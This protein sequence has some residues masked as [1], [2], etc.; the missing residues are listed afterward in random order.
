MAMDTLFGMH[1]PLS[2]ITYI[3]LLRACIKGKSLYQTR[4]VR[5]HLEK[6]RPQKELKGLLG[7]YLVVALARCGS[8][9]DAHKLAISLQSRTVYSWS[10]LISSYVDSDR[11]EDALYMWK[12]MCN[13]GIFPNH[14]T[15]VSLFKACA[16]IPDLGQGMEL[17]VDA[18][19]QGFSCDHLVGNTIVSMYGKCGAIAEAENVFVSLNQ[20]DIVSWNV[21]LSIY[22]E[23]QERP[24]TVFQLYIQMQREGIC[25]DQWTFAIMLHACA[26]F[27][28][29]I[30]YTSTFRFQEEGVPI[31]M[32]SK[33]IR[34]VSLDIGQ[35]LH[36]DARKKGCMSD[37][38]VGN[39][40]LHLLGK[41]G[42]VQQAETMFVGLSERDVV[43]WNVMLS[44]YI[45]QGQAV[46]PLQLYLKLQEEGESPDQLTFL[47]L[48]QACGILADMKEAS[49]S[50]KKEHTM[51]EISLKIG[52]ALHDDACRRGF[53]ADVVMVNALVTMYGKCGTIAELEN[54]FCMLSHRDIVTWNTMLS[55]YAK[56][57]LG[58]RALKLYDKLK[59]ELVMVDDVTLTSVLQAC[60]ETGNLE[61]CKQLQFEI[62]SMSYDKKPSVVATLIHSY[63]SCAS[64][65]EA[66]RTFNELRVPDTVTW[67]AYI[68]SHG[69][70]DNRKATLNLF[71]ELKLESTTPSVE[72]FIIMLTYCCRT[73]LVCEGIECFNSMITCY[74]IRPNIKHYGIMVDLLGRAGD[75]R[76]VEKMLAFMPIQADLTVW[77]SLLGACRTHMNLDLAQQAFQN[78]LDLQST[79]PT[80]YILL[81]NIYEDAEIQKHGV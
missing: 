67:N 69:S 62:V 10:A 21:I 73:G 32:S 71:E 28:C 58:E 23:Q 26:S 44:A 13:E 9:E 45:D 24:E 60:G 1:S 77:L 41:C 55:A 65:I 30:S 79:H 75:F 14:Y 53:T 22:T 48:F 56:Q 18:C 35:A 46:K 63:G 17:H 38:L 49:L 36:A 33:S 19:K 43:T 64:V 52:Q 50:E 2:D 4:R 11:G 25:P 59:T 70:G 7:D 16:T 31:D 42:T 76:K 20:R 29:N 74:G 6:H 3:S 80:A 40:L 57:G 8:A 5:E 68:T 37:I 34:L 51:K 12:C 81:S 39:T 72:S 78:A 66:I 15:F 61:L 54:L 47:L 27:S